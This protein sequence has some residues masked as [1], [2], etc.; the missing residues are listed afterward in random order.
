MTW[1]QR[2]TKGQW[3]CSKVVQ[4]HAERAC[5]ELRDLAKG[6]SSCRIGSGRPSMRTSP[7]PPMRLPLMAS[8]IASTERPPDLS[9]APRTTTAIMQPGC[10]S[11]LFAFRRST[12]V[13]ATAGCPRAAAS[14]IRRCVHCV[15]MGTALCRA[16]WPEAVAVRL[17]SFWPWATSGAPGARSASAQ[18]RCA[19]TRGACTRSGSTSPMTARAIHS[20]AI[21]ATVLIAQGL[22]GARGSS[23]TRAASAPMWET[24]SS[25]SGARCLRI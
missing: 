21:A 19:S 24:D 15:L 20:W 6:G 14:W 12:S 18:W 9:F 7:S 4:L 2:T 16:C 10:S 25:T 3:N 8:C 5:T 22:C 23:C 17:R 13:S 1:R 11:P